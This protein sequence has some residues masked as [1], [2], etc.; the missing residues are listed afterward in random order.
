MRVIEMELKGVWKKISNEVLDAINYYIKKGTYLIDVKRIRKYLGI[1]SYDRS[2]INFI[3]RFLSYLKEE[4]LIECLREK[5]V[6]RFKLPSKTFLLFNDQV[7]NRIIVC[8]K[9]KSNDIKILIHNPVIFLCN[10]C[11]NIWKSPEMKIINE[12]FNELH[13]SHGI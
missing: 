1:R 6:R 13:Y 5:P 3:W 7:E 12:Q 4:N 8:E 2:K 9:C 10:E 11:G